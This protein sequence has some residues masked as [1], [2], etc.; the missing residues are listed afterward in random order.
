MEITGKL[1]EIFPVMTGTSAKGE[2][3]RQDFLIET[4]AQFPKKIFMAN[5]NDKV[6][7]KEEYKNKIVKISFDLESRE[8]NGR[9]YTDVKPWKLEFAEQTSNPQFVAEKPTQNEKTDLPWDNDPVN[10]LPF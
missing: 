8:Y 5:W 2:W 3:K 1:I 9:W 7:L 10:D 4:Q 6:D